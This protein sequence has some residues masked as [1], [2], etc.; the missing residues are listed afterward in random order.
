MATNKFIDSFTD[1]RERSTAS[2]FTKAKEEAEADNNTDV[3]KADKNT[4]KKPKEDTK[5]V[6]FNLTL[7]PKVKD[8][9]NAIAYAD[10]TSVNAIVYDLLVKYI[11]DNKEKLEEGKRLLK[12]KGDNNND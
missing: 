9:I 6:R 3:S 5:S 11:D 1:E 7:T 2:F 10:R 8:D 4:R 12:Q